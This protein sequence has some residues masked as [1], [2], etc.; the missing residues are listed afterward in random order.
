MTTDDS[1]VR[2]FR[3]GAVCVV[4]AVLPFL[5]D[6][7]RIAADTKIDLT[8][9]P[10]A[11]LGRS[12]SMW[13]PLGFFGQLQNQAYGYLFPMGPFFAVGESLGIP[14]WAIQRAW[15]SLLLVAAFLGVYRLAGMLGIKS[16]V[17]CVLAGLAYA[18]APRM[19][20][21]LGPISAEILPF[22]I[23]P[24]VLIPLIHGTIQ[25]SPR[26]WAALS[27]LALVF[28]GGINAVAVTAILPLP[29]WWLITH[30]REKRV[31][32]LSAWWA[33][34]VS[35]ASL[36]WLIPLMVQGRY[37]PPFLDWIESASTTTRFTDPARV[38]TGANQWVAYVAE[39]G[40]PSWPAGWWVANSGIAILAA[41]LLAGLGLLGI[42]RARSLRLFLLGGVLI[43]FALVSMGH[44]GAVFSGVGS[45]NVQG[46]LDG[47]LAPLRNT[48]KFDVVLRLPL[49]LGIG[50][51]VVAAQSSRIRIV[52]STCVTVCAGLVAV[53]AWPILTGGITRD[54]TYV[55][56]PGYW[57][58][59]AAWLNTNGSNGR[60]LVVPGA[61]FGTYIWGR[62]QDEPLEALSNSPWVVRDAVP[63]ANAGTIRWLDA[64]QSRLEDGLGSPGLA[65]ALARVGV[66]HVLV[67]NDLDTQRS[68]APPSVFVR[69]SLV[70][71]G[72][73]MLVASF[74]STPTPYRVSGRVARHGP[75][76][77]APA[78]EIWSV[79]SDG[80]DPRVTLRDA[81]NVLSVS[82]ASESVLDLI[83]ANIGGSA[84]IV[85][86]GDPLPPNLTVVQG[87]TDGFRNQEVSFGTTRHN[88]S[89]TLTQGK[90][91]VSSARVTDYLPA[92]GT[93]AQTWATYSGGRTTASSSASSPENLGGT[94]PDRAPY[95]AVDADPATSWMAGVPAQVGQWWQIDFERDIDPGS[96]RIGWPAAEGGP[97]PQSVV[98]TTDAGAF[99]FDVA[100]TGEVQSFSVPGAT[101]SLR[102]T[103]AGVRDGAV[104]QFGI[105]DI[106]IPHADVQR[107]LVTSGEI[108]GGPGVFSTARGAQ[109]GC[110][111]VTR[112][113]VCAE[114]M[115][116]HS[117]DLGI[118]RTFSVGAPMEARITLTGRWLGGP[119]LNAAL[120][121]GSVAATSDSVAVVDPAARPEA[122]VD[123]NAATAW[124]AS[125]SDAHPSLLL[126]LS[127]PRLISG[128]RISVNASA[129]V[130]RPVTVT[131]VTGGRTTTS[132]IG[133][134]GTVNFVPVT[135]DEVLIRVENS[136]AV[137]TS[138]SSGGSVLIPVGISEVTILGDPPNPDIS[139]NQVLVR[140]GFGPNILID[141]IRYST[142]VTTTVGA[143]VAN[144]EAKVTT[145]G[146]ST[147]ALSAG[148]HTIDVEPSQV[149]TPTRISLTPVNNAV[150][151]ADPISPV[152]LSWGS[153]S[154]AVEVLE[155]GTPRM[156]ETSENFNA[157][158]QA[159]AGDVILTPVQVDGWRQAWLVP[160]GMAGAVTLEFT[161]QSIFGWGLVI[162]ALAVLIL[163]GLAAV[164]AR[165]AVPSAGA[166]MSTQVWTLPI[167]LWIVALLVGGAWLCLS[168]VLV[169]VLVSVSPRRWGSRVQ[170]AVIGLGVVIAGTA[171]WQGWVTLATCAA[172]SALSAALWTPPMSELLNRTF[173]RE[174]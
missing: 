89:E 48:H 59:A 130:S 167:M 30:F 68:D 53:I 160:A 47:V 71:S 140:C 9:D 174:P 4:L 32:I 49:A 62:P 120:P 153:T 88:R 80:L 60:T 42:T 150:V 74:G 27:G 12:L 156:L 29:A 84:P 14:A 81:S 58:E 69:D 31:R 22:A 82:G 123:G 5:S 10:W 16:P 50:F 170:V 137:R 108:N 143:V 100:A 112:V 113:F 146:K 103:L 147:I 149:V 33:L 107:T 19:V 136:T 56:I 96:V 119:E 78:I 66:T 124:I 87:V 86:S 55:E 44:V 21:E 144:E 159:R 45:E 127:R 70:A 15:W 13:E 67:R 133:A 162:G 129:V 171:T 114:A 35:L 76:R 11:F 57:S 138:D 104:G 157:G 73:F 125:A 128:L 163:I 38:L 105:R 116:T 168:A 54:R 121:R 91:Y 18:L 8:A 37:S 161:P 131:V 166:R 79:A 39:R 158:W 72:G 17:A 20:T 172:V 117:E 36:W 90:S 135:A 154:R 142:A 106:A 92:R 118:H 109:P 28:A 25:G 41:A 151:V 52:R 101:R 75:D 24:W 3:V 139:E 155:S 111:R 115:R 77:A 34:A 2:R 95:A 148:S 64:V 61:S 134:D 43:G 26:R 40:G 165:E 173:K 141:E 63:L 169:L 97:L 132:A 102:V 1:L 83:D 85:M 164:P 23:A 6:P 99:T 51:V 7:G 98:L 46:W 145:C 65:A 122:A 93:Q 110:I 152:V 94:F 126:T